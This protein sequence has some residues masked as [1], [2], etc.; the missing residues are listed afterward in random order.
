[1][2]G[3]GFALNQTPKGEQSTAAGYWKRLA[4]ETPSA[5]DAWSFGVAGMSVTSLAAPVSGTVS[6][7]PKPKMHRPEFLFQFP[8]EVNAN[9]RHLE[10]R[11]LNPD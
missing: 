7:A 10:N 8:A 5:A 2:K 4:S 11:G 3:L 1:M 9:G 6:I